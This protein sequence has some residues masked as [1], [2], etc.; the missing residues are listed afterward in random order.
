MCSP[1][2][3]WTSAN[4]TREFS[5]C[6]RARALRDLQPKWNVEE[7]I[8]A[9]SSIGLAVLFQHSVPSAAD[10]QLHLSS[11]LWSLM[12]MQ[13]AARIKKCHVR[14]QSQFLITG[15]FKF[16]RRRMLVFSESPFPSYYAEQCGLWTTGRTEDLTVSFVFLYN[17][18]LR[19]E[20]LCFIG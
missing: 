9:I 13:P 10:W 20:I 15:K 17:K 7:R 6:R 2:K 19:K 14:P 12:H 3:H 1:G 18:T 11:P 4:E 5:C 16:R 8:C